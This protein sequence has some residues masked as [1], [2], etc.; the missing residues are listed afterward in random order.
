[1]TEDDTFNTLR[2]IPYEQLKKSHPFDLAI[3]ETEMSLIYRNEKYDREVIKK[4]NFYK[5]YLPF[6]KRK[7]DP[8]HPYV[9]AEEG[10]FKFLDGTG[11]TYKDIKEKV[12]REEE[13]QDKFKKKKKRNEK[14]AV[15]FIAVAL[16]LISLG[17]Y[18]LTRFPTIVMIPFD[19]LIMYF[20]VDII[21]SCLN[22]LL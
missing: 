5:K 21:S 3:M 16:T 1:M 18:A 2:R 17:I 13:R 6:I 15:F 11:W 20:G 7:E 22:K 9:P 14:L 10:Y 19:I 12:Y 8:L 4:N